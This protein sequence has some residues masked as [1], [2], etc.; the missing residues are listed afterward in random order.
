MK[1]VRWDLD[2]L[3]E[4]QKQQEIAMTSTEQV[5]NKARND[6]NSMTEEVWEGE[7]GDIAR[8]LLGYL[9]YKEMPQ[10]W[11]EIDAIN[12]AIKKAQKTAYESKNFYRMV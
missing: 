6:L 11:K 4:V 1:R 8:E 9:V 10:T 5:I 12:I 2:Q 7:D 3:K